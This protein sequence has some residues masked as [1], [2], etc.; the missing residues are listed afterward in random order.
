MCH[1]EVSLEVLWCRSSPAIA[2]ALPGAMWYE[3]QRDLQM[4]ATFGGLGGDWER[5]SCVLGLAAS[6]ARLRAA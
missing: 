6:S 4:I 3:L 5:L 2:C 1:S